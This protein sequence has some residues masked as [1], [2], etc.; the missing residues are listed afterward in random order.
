MQQTPEHF[1][2]S[3]NNSKKNNIN[4]IWDFANSISYDLAKN[5]SEIAFFLVP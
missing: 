5:T 2:N 3:E 1:L 4:N